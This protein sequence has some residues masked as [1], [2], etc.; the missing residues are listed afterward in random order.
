MSGSMLEDARENLLQ[1]IK[2]D[3]GALDMNR[4]H[5]MLQGDLG[6]DSESSLSDLSESDAEVGIE[7]NQKLAKNGIQRLGVRA[8]GSWRCAL[9]FLLPAFAF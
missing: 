5:G 1:E 2:D 9:P 7:V 6:G 8:S 3:F 4:V